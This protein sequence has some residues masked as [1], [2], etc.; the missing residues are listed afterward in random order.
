MKKILC[1]LI[2]FTGVLSSLMAQVPAHFDL[3]VQLRENN[4]PNNEPLRDARLDVEIT[5][6][7]GS[8]EVYKENQSPVWTN[9]DGYLSIQ[10]GKGN[11]TQWNNIDWNAATKKIRIKG[12]ANGANTPYN[13]LLYNG[14][15]PVAAYAQFVKTYERPGVG[16]ISIF[17]HHEHPSIELLGNDPNNNY[18]HIDFASNTSAADR[19]FVGRI[20]I[21]DDK[22]MYF[23]NRGN[24]YYFQKD[25]PASQVEVWTGGNAGI[26]LKGGDP[27][28]D[29]YETKADNSPRNGRIIV[30]GS[31]L[32]IQSSR[33]NIALDA[34]SNKITYTA[35]QHD[36]NGPIIV[37]GA[38]SKGPHNISYFS[39]NSASYSAGNT[40]S[41]TYD[42]S[43]QTNSRI[44][45]SSLHVFSDK[46]LKVITGY[47]NKSIEI[48]R[49]LRVV[50]YVYRDSLEMGKNRKKGFV[51]QEVERVFP[52]AVFKTTG[53]IP[54]IFQ[55]GKNVIYD[56]D[57]KTLIVT[58]DSL[59]DLKVGEKVRLIGEQQHLVEVVE[60][61]GTTFKVKDW[62]EENTREVF[63]YGREVDDFRT[64]DYDQIF[65]LNVS[66]TQALIKEVD[67]LKT[68][69]AALKEVNESL[70]SE[71]KTLKD[72]LRKINGRIEALA[73]M[74]GNGNNH[75][76]VSNAGTNS[77]GGIE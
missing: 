59:S 21:D 43:I 66:A 38:K 46:R 52:E 20:R 60:V 25:P 63:V 31:T 5:I 3:N 68:Q 6:L 64:L 50:N 30:E 70:Q 7:Q 53:V 77:G 49:K 73:K 47:T 27:R 17:N 33:K 57:T 24:V 32:S 12:R 55:I 71:N 8:T 29:F 19:D 16:S 58:V 44:L 45:T 65:T 67:E 26:N 62:P 34:G 14:D 37:T 1:L 22:C 23:L 39:Y 69:L 56:E 11:P 40:G 48:F 15:L 76:A 72:E 61:N 74:I 54:D 4:D 28:I 2:V 36:F 41:G 9:Y 18:P 35:S 75:A 13:R 51:A 10:V 42:Y